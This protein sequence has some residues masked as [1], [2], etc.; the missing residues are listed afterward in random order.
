MVE[1]NKLES[2]LIKRL[3]DSISI[4]Q[5]SKTK[6][7]RGKYYMEESSRAINLLNLVRDSISNRKGK[8]VPTND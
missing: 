6:R 4:R 5:T 8:F 3:D 2:M 7:H 1:I